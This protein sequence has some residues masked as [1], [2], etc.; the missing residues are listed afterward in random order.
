M[1][2]GEERTGDSR[3]L[4]ALGMTARKAKAEANARAGAEAQ[5]EVVAG[6]REEADSQRE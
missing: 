3:M 5:A 4:A 6:A 1:V 2:A